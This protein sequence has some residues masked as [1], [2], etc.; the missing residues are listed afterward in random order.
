M[1]RK[2]KPRT[3]MDP[4]DK[5]IMIR[6]WMYESAA[7][8]SL[9]SVARDLLNELIYRFNGQNNGYVGLSHRQALERIG[10]K[11]NRAITDAF[12]EL[13]TKGFIRPRAI[14]SFNLKSRHST[15]WILTHLDY[16]GRELTKE[17]MRWHPPDEK[18]SRGADC[19]PTGCNLHAVVPFTNAR[20]A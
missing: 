9:S 18:K 8:R 14:G 15:E 10:T 13:Q 6:R 17:F 4:R 11:S 19:M 1:A 7:Y 3:K 20:K 5:F 16:G 2:R 12:R